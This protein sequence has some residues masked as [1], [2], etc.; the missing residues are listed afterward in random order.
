MS[1][2][3]IIVGTGAAGYGLLRALRHI[4]SKRAV[5]LVTSD[6]GAAYSK[7]Q[8][9]CSL[10]RN[11]DARDLVLA[12]PEQ[13]AQRY[14]A[15]IVPSTRVIGVDSARRV[16]ITDKDERP[17]GQLVLATGAEALR[18]AAL[19]GMASSRVLTVSSL[20]DYAYLRSELQGRN[21]VAVI[22]GGAAACEFAENL[23]RAGCETTQFGSARR[24]LH[25]RLPG[26]CAERLARTLRAGGVRLRLEDGIQRVEPGLDDL[27]LVTLS[28]MRMTVDVVVAALGSRPRTMIADRAGLAVQEAIV[29]DRQLRTSQADI[30]AVGECAELVGRRFTTP[31]DIDS[32]ARVLATNLA[33]GSARM[34][35]TPRLQRLQ[36]ES[37]PTVLCDPPPVAGEWQETA[38]V[39]GV[40]ALFHDRR[41]DLRGFALVGSAVDEAARL[42]GQLP[43]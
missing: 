23:V 34:Q 38:T 1:G 5:Q 3:L 31:D 14:D 27:E 18:P 37:C 16:L 11:K 29:V 6:D 24:L 4:D 25:G 28:G 9:A 22:G 32:A 40:K 42:L 20:A 10:A 12:T 30:F 35:W 26:L 17:Y 19:R 2:P 39:T 43:G 41:G 8:F 21:R 13:M 15:K 33:G 36:I 7:F